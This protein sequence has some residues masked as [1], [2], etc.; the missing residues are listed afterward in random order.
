[1]IFTWKSKVNVRN[2]QH[3]K[4]LRIRKLFFVR[5][6]PKKHFSFSVHCTSSEPCASQA[7]RNVRQIDTVETTNFFAPTKLITRPLNQATK[8]Q[9][10][11]RQ[12]DFIRTLSSA[13]LR[14]ELLK[15][16]LKRG[17]R[18]ITG[19]PISILQWTKCAV[20]I[21]LEYV[22]SFSAKRCN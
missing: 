15:S 5:L 6:A 18:I 14:L 7:G 9:V 12:F 4:Q 17:N 10:F 8:P 22:S 21:S 13:E 3:K 20:A 2:D 16:N 1:M 19:I 11:C